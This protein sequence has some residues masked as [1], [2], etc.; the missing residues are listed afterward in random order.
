MS[1][2]T[3]NGSA[4]GSG[5]STPN[6]VF[7]VLHRNGLSPSYGAIGAAE[8][9]AEQSSEAITTITVTASVRCTGTL[10]FGLS[11]LLFEVLNR[12]STTFG[13]G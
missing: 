6:P 4:P 1:Y 3:Q 8:A 10:P 12:C 7:W 9:A 5:K 2:L 13:S 11:T